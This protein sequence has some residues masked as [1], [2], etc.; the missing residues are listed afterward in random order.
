MSALGQPAMGAARGGRIAYAVRALAL[1]A[2][3]A[4]LAA[5][6]IAFVVRPAPADKHKR[7]V[8]VVVDFRKFHEGIKVGCDPTRPKNGLVALTK[9]G[10]SYSFVPRHPAS[11]AE[12]TKSPGSAT[13]LPRRRTGRTGMPDHTANGCTAHLAPRVITRKPDGSKAGLSATASHPAYPL[14]KQHVLLSRA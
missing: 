12:S 14:P 3:A 5:A 1:L 8:T 11:S 7:G 2:V 10:F 4:L 13:A 6:L 9:A